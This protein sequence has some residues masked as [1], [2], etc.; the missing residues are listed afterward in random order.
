VIPEN[1]NMLTLGI[2]LKTIRKFL[3]GEDV[4]TLFLGVDE[5]QKIDG[6]DY[7][8]VSDDLSFP[9][10]NKI[11][12]LLVDV[13]LTPTPAL[14]VLPLF[15]RTDFQC[16]SPASSS[17]HLTKRIPPRLLKPKEIEKA[18]SFCEDFMLSLTPCQCRLRLLNRKF[19]I[20]SVTLSRNKP[21]ATKLPMMPV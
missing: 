10:L 8:K 11:L 16:T 3:P 1:A 6:Y 7:D 9:Q 4:W 14:V 2:A 19:L 20:M 17:A 13:M 15:A 18:V 21:N 5:Y 12:D